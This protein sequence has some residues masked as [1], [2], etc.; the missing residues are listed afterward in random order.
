[1]SKPVIPISGRVVAI[2][3]AARGLGLAAAKALAA[4]GAR[5]AIGDLDG[6]LARV[7]A[8]ALPGPGPHAGYALDVTDPESFEAFLDQAAELGA[9]DVIINNAGIMPVRAFAQADPIVTRRQ[10]EINLLG[11]MTGTRLALDRMLPR[12]SGHIVNVA[13]AAGR[14]AVPGE[15]VYTATKHA[16]VGFDEALRVELRPKGIDVSTIMPSLAATELASGMQPPRFVPMVKPEQV[17]KAIVKTLER[18]KLEVIVPAW[19]T[20]L[21]RVTLAMPPNLRDKIRHFFRIEEVGGEI[22]TSARAA[23]EERSER[24]VAADE[25]ELASH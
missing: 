5:V 18:P 19:T 22:D 16:V 21:I 14:V 17:A 24:P 6:D 12:G 9:L 15:A 7:E 2:T 20:P 8:A 25:H 13:S 3:G 10:V 23:Y 1:M 11:V 4:R